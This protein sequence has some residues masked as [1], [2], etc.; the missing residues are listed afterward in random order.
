LGFG[1]AL[2]DDL[3]LVGDTV[4]KSFCVVD[5]DEVDDQEYNYDD[6]NDDKNGNEVQF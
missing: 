4:R 1:I 5:E 2:V 3:F 6:D